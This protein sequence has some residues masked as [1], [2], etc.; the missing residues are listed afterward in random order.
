MKLILALLVSLMAMPIY[1]EYGPYSA[2]LIRV[3]DGDTVEI[4]VPLWPGLTK[5]TKLRLS[6]VNTPEMRRASECEKKAG[7][8]AKEFTVQ[9]LAPGNI[10]VT[11]VKNGKFAGRVLG[12]I[13]VNGHSLGQALIFSGLA[14]P[15]SGGKRLPWC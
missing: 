7:Q 1:A 15:Y 9:F 13:H 4:L 2:K 10:V 11:D 12:N 14:K 6:G 8:Q 5:T 3:L